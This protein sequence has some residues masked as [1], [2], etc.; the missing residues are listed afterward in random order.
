MAA[1][2][3]VHE[4]LVW[5][6]CTVF[7]RAVLEGSVMSCVSAAGQ[8]CPLLGNVWQGI[9]PNLGRDP[10]EEGPPAQPQGACPDTRKGGLDALPVSPPPPCS[11]RCCAGT[12]LWTY[13][14]R[15]WGTLG[16]PL[17]AGPELGADLSMLWPTWGVS[18]CWPLGPP[19]GSAGPPRMQLWVLSPPLM[20]VQGL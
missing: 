20:H 15:A 2:Q 13:V 8:G 19:V 17:T 16:A 11:G 10:R 5:I 6:L 1:D 18:R 9:H 3:S 7:L 14:P 12:R 4:G